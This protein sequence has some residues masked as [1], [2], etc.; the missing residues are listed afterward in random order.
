MS[1]CGMKE[2]SFVSASSSDYYVESCG[3]RRIWSSN[4]YY[5]VSVCGTE[6]RLRSKQF[7]RYFSTERV[8]IEEFVYLIYHVIEDVDLEA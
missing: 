3:D 7:R 4:I 2:V 8:E 6:E 5:Y 1:E